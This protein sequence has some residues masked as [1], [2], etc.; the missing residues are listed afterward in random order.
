MAS[1]PRTLARLAGHQLGVTTPQR[2]FASLPVSP[3]S[4]VTSAAQSIS[5]FGTTS[6][7]R[8]PALPST[9]SV[10]AAST[11]PISHPI[12][13]QF[14]RAYADAAPQPPKKNPGKIRR[15]FRWARR[16]TYLSILG[17]IGAVA[18]DGYKDR[19]PDEQY[20][21][22]PQKKTLVVLGKLTSL[23]AIIRPFVTPNL[24]HCHALY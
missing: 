3:L 5:R 24:V 23:S 7:A 13:R 11:H 1:S 20:T 8:K 10:L 4:P 17:L 9:S 22:D 2:L 6:C 14:Q 19:Y 12:S 18:Y 16:L 21:P 15:T